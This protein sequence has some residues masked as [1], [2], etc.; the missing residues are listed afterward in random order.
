MNGVACSRN[1]FISHSSKDADKASEVCRYL[2]KN[3]VNCWIAPRDV[4]PG[5]NYPTQLV[6]AIQDCR[7]FVL[8][9]SEN[10]NVS[11][12]VSNE[13]ELASADTDKVIIP[14]MLEDVEYSEEHS[15]Y[16]RR[17]QRI[18]AYTN[19]ED[20]LNN[21]LS[22]IRLHTQNDYG[23][24]VDAASQAFYQAPMQ[25]PQDK[26]ASAQTQQ[27]AGNDGVLKE[28]RLGF[29]PKLFFTSEMVTLSL[30]RDRLEWKGD[31]IG[32]LVRVIPIKEISSIKCVLKGDCYYHM[33]IKLDNKKKY[34]F[35][36][37]NNKISEQVRGEGFLQ[38][39]EITKLEA[40]SWYNAIN[41]VRNGTFG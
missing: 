25:Q 11:E 41:S 27:Q 10:T 35:E 19:F 5:A 22:T 24:K 17:K 40:E 3:G 29:Y 18:N 4:N 36:M 34:E 23:A 20:G 28:G 7:V 6:K 14:F 12:P 13:I 8:L 21:L 39:V 16:L 31:E 9:V 2:E 15:Y 37:R 26:P 1:V 38:S 33:I 30:Y 32:A